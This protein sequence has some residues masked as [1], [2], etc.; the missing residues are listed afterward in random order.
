M[1]KLSIIITLLAM[2]ISAGCNKTENTLESDV[3]TNSDKPTIIRKEKEVVE[4][5]AVYGVGDRVQVRGDYAV[6]LIGVTEIT[7]AEISNGT[8]TLLIEFLYE[9]ISIDENHPVHKLETSQSNGFELGLNDG[10]PSIRDSMDLSYSQVVQHTPVGTKSL[11][12][13]VYHNE[14]G[15]KR[16][17]FRF[18]DYQGESTEFQADIGER[19]IPD[20]KGKMPE[21]K[22]SYKI[23]EPMILVDA[24][25]DYTITV[26]SVRK[27]DTYPEDLRIGDL[28]LY[29]VL[30]SYSVPDKDKFSFNRF[31]LIPIDEMGNTGYTVYWKKEGYPVELEDGFQIPMYVATHIDSNKLILY[32]TQ[33]Y[34]VE[35]GGY[36]IEVDDIK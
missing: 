26:D 20:M 28:F 25:I 7:D 6:T 35:K 4:E 23:G 19:I 36:F 11:Q 10:V 18:P 16:F 5:K 3:E 15:K 32:Y 13:F 2:V 12:K 1:K 21:Y 9:N 29:E 22:K 24:K 8:Q 33:D 17:D 30:M 34:Q 14:S 31:D 27:M